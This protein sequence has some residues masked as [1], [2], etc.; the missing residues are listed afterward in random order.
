MLKIHF[1]QNVFDFSLTRY[2]KFQLIIFHLL[3][4]IFKKRKNKKYLLHESKY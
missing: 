4:T 2:I 1:P 3:L